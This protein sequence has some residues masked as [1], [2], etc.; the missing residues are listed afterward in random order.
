MRL[1][2]R[3]NTKEVLQQ[4]GHLVVHDPKAYRGRWAELFG[5]DHPIHV[6]LGMGKGRFISL[7][8][9]K[10]P[11][12]N[13]IGVDLYDELVRKTCE[14]AEETRKAWK[15]EHGREP[16]ANLKVARWNVENIEEMFAPGEIERIYLNFSDPWPKNRHANRRLTHPKFLKRYRNILNANGEIHFKTDSTSLFEFSLN[17][18]AEMDLMMRN[19][20]LDLHGKGTPPD[21]I[22]TEYEEKFASQGMKIYRV[23]VIVGEQAQAR[24]REAENSDQ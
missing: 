3:P 9:L 6:E 7:M 8:S 22:M 19:I 14:K 12:W 23:E 17:A 24:R 4:M 5:N 10:Y 16:A 21:Q 13:F 2:R 20:S 11:E 15:E 1:R 18:F